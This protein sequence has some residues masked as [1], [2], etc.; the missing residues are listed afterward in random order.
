MK[1]KVEK[2]TIK[3]VK[4]LVFIF[5]VLF[6]GAVWGQVTINSVIAQSPVHFAENSDFSVG[7]LTISFN[8]PTGKTSGELQVNLAS[9]IEYM[10]GTVTA[11]G[12]TVSLKTGSTDAN[13]PVF[14]LTG[15]SGSVTVKLKRKATKAVLT[16]PALAS[17][18]QDEAVLTVQGLAPSPA[19]K[20]TAPY[21][22][23]RPTL[24]VQLPTIQT[25]VLGTRTE[26]FDIRNT[27]NGIVKD[28]YFSIAYDHRDVVGLSVSHNGTPL[29]QVGTVPTGLPNAGKPIYKIANANLANNGVVT[30]TEKYTVNKCTT[31]RQ[32]IY[33]AYWGSAIANNE[34]IFETNSNTRNISVSTGTP[35]IK[36]NGSNAF[37]YFE[38]KNGFCGNILGTYYVR[39]DNVTADAKGTAYNLEI[40]L[41]DA[42]E[43][44]KFS[45]F[46]PV[47]IRLIAKNGT[48]IPLA[49][50]LDTG[51]TRRISLSNLPALSDTSLGATDFGLTDAD[52]DGFR[53]DLKKGDYFQIAFDL[54]K[55]EGITCLQPR[56]GVRNFL[57]IQP[58]SQVLSSNV[59]GDLIPSEQHIL[60]NSTLRVYFNGVNDAS[61]LPAQ[62]VQNVPS[63]AYIA[64]GMNWPSLGAGQR[65]KNG[66]AVNVERQFKYV[67]T[68]PAGMKLQN[69]KLYRKANVFGVSTEA[70]VN[71]PDIE[72]NSTRTIITN[73]QPSDSPFGTPGYLTFDVLLQNCNGGTAPI[74]YS[75]YMMLKNGDGTY[76]DIPLVCNQVTNVPAICSTPCAIQGPRMLSTKVERADNSYGWKDHT[77]AIRQT[78]A[79]V[80][81]IERMRAL[82]LDDIEFISEGQQHVSKTDT[83]LFYYVKVEKTAELE[84]KKITLKVNG[85]SEQ[86]LIATANNPMRGTDAAGKKYFRWNLTSLLP[87]GTLVAGATF[88]TVATYQVKN[89]NNSNSNDRALDVQSGTES[90]FYTLD[91]PTTDTN[92]SAEGYHTAQKHCGANLTP[93]FY[94]AET[95]H[96]LA[97]N[98]YTELSG[99]DAA[100]L[101]SNLIYAARR[102]KPGGTYF[103]QEFRPAR[104]IKKIT[105]KMPSA[106]QIKNMQFTYTYKMGAATAATVDMSKLIMTDDGTWKTYTYENPPKGTL[107]YLPPGMITVENEYN[108]YIKA[109]IQPSCKAKTVDVNKKIEQQEA[110]AL[111]NQEKIDS[112]IEY[113]DFY[114][115]YADTGDSSVAV[116]LQNNR[117]ILFAESKKPEITIEAISQLTVKANKR[118]ME[119]TFKLKNAKSYDAPFGWIS[120]PDVTGIEVLSLEEGGHTYTAQNSISGEKM[121]FLSDK[122][123]DGK[124]LKN[125][126]RQF[127]LKYKITNCAAALQLKVYAGWNCN[128]DPTTGYRNTCSDKFITYNI[129]VAQSK[130]EIRADPTNPGENKPNKKGEIPM[131]APTTYKYEIN[132]AEEGDI[133]NAKLV[134]TQGNGITISN[135]KVEYPLGGTVYTVG[136]GAG[137]ILHTQS[138]NR[139]TYDISNILPEGSLPG[140][141][142]EPN[143]ANKRKFKLTFDV[144]P[145][146][147][148]SAGSSFDIDVEGTNLCDSP[149]EG[150]KT[151]AIIAGITGANVPD[152]GVQI[153]MDKDLVGNL[154]SCGNS[155]V[156]EITAAITHPTPLYQ[157]NSTE[158][159]VHVRIPK[160][161]ELKSLEFT[162]PPVLL[163]PPPFHYPGPTERKED[164]E[165]V[166]GDEQELVF[167]IPKYA[168]P[169]YTVGWILELQQ[170]D[171]AKVP[172]DPSKIKAFASDRVTGIT[173]NGQACPTLPR[174]ITSTTVEKNLIN[175]RPALSFTDLNI[176]SAAKSGKEELTIKYKLSNAVTTTN[177]AADLPATQQVKIDLYKDINN[178]GRFDAA[179]TKLSTTPYTFQEAV[180]EGASSSEKTITALVDQGDVCRLLLVINNDTNKCLCKDVYTQ[181][182][183]PATLT[184]LVPNLTVCEGETK[185]VAY[186]AA[187]YEVYTWSGKTIDDN[188]TYLSA[189]NVKEP[190]F[191]YTGTKLTATKSFTYILKV[192]RTNGCEAT[193]E[194]TVTVTP[195]TAAP[196]NKEV[197]FCQGDN[198]KVSTLKTKLLALYPGTTI[199]IYDPSDA[200]TVLT[201]NNDVAANANYLFTI[202]RTG[203]C[204][205]RQATVYVKGITLPMVAQANQTFCGSATVAALQPHGANYV[206]YAAATGGA[207]LT[208]STALTN[209]TYYVAKKNGTCESERVAVAVQL[210]TPIA[211]G[212]S[213]IFCQGATVY[214]LKK[215]LDATRPESVRIY[216]NNILLDRDNERLA[217]T[218]TFK[219]S[220]ATAACETAKVDVG[221]T[222]TSLAVTKLSATPAFLPAQGGSVTF[223]IEGTPGAKVSYSVGGNT[224]EVTLNTSGSATTTPV[225]APNGATIT[226]TKIEKGDC[227]QSLNQ[228]LTV[229]KACE[230][231]PTPQFAT[232]RNS[233]A[234]MNGVVVHR[235]VSGLVRPHFTN[236]ITAS[237]A[238]NAPY[239][240]GYVHMH[241]TRSTKVVYTFEKPINSVDVFLM[242]MGEQFYVDYKDR[243]RFEVNCGTTTLNIVNECKAGNAS[244]SG[245]VL[246]GSRL[247]DVV[248]RVSSDKPF[249]QLIVRQNNDLITDGYAM[250][251]CPSS[252]KEADL[253]Q[254]ITQPQPTT[255][256]EGSVAR[257]TSKATLPQGFTGDIGYQWQVSPNGTSSWS[258]VGTTRYVNSGQEVEFLLTNATPSQHD[259]RYYRVR[260]TY[261]NTALICDTK[262]TDYSQAAK[263]T[264]N[265]KAELTKLTATPGSI[266]QGVS[267]SVTFA[268]KGTP[269]AT[270]VYT[271]AGGAPSEVTLDTNGDATKILPLSQA[272]TLAVVQVKTASCTYPSSQKVQVTA[273]CGANKPEPLFA[274][275][276]EAE[277]T[278]G[279]VKVTRKLTGTPTFSGV[280]N[281][282]AFCHGNFQAGYV[283]MG[284][285]LPLVD[286]TQKVE[287]E[288]DTPVTNAEIWLMGMGISGVTN[289]NFKETA[290]ISVDCGHIQLSKV[291][292]CKNAA[293]INGQEVEGKRLTDVVVR[294]TSDNPFTKITIEDINSDRIAAG[295]YVALCPSSIQ[296]AEVLTVVEDPQT[297][298]LCEGKN[299]TFTAKV[300]RETGYNEAIA[301][302]WEQST[303]NGNTWTAVSGQSGTT[304]GDAQSLNLT[305]ITRAM[306]E[307]WY[308]VKYTYTEATP[309]RLCNGVTIT[310][311]TQKAQLKVTGLDK[312]TLTQVSA[313]DCTN[314]R[315]M[316]LGNVETD[317]GVTY[318]FVNT[319]T[320][321][322]VNAA[323][324]R[325]DGTI[326]GLPA[327]T[328]KVTATKNGCSSEAS[329]VFT[330]DA[331][332]APA[333]PTVQEKTFA[334]CSDASVV[335]I[336]N[337]VAGNYTFTK[338][339]GTA[340]TET[341]TVDSADGTITGLAVGKYKVKVEKDGCT[342]A[343]SAVFEIKDK[344]QPAKPRIQTVANNCQDPTAVTLTNY[345]AGATYSFVKAAD[346]SAVAE[347]INI[348]N[349][350]AV[351]GLVAGTYKVKV[352]VNDCVSDLSD[353]FEVKA[354]KAGTAI[355]TQPQGHNYAKNAT[356]DEIT[357]GATGEGNLRYK[358]FMNT[359]NS[360]TGADVREIT[361]ATTARYTPA[362]RTV[363]SLFYWVEV[364]GDCD[365]KESDIVEIKVTET[366]AAI[367]ANN[368]TA[369]VRRGQSVAVLPNDYVGGNPATLTNVTIAIDSNDG[370]TGATIDPQGRIKVPTN[371]TPGTYNVV[372]KICLV[373]DPNTCDNATAT[374]TVTNDPAYT[375]EANDDPLTRVAKGGTV[376]VLS[377]DQVNGNP[378]TPT[379]MDMTIEDNGGLSN[380]EVNTATGKLKVPADATPGTYE[381]TYR[382]C[383]KGETSPCD[384]AKVKIEVTSDAAPTKTI[385]ANDDPN[386]SVAKGGSVEVLSN[387]RLNGEP[388]TKDKVTITIDNDAGLTGVEID[389]ATGKI[390]VP[391]TAT[392]D[393]YEVTYKICDKQN[394]ALCDNANVKITVTSDVIHTIDANDDPAV[395][396][397]KGGTVTVLDNDQVDG[398]TATKDTVDISIVNHGNLTG[399]TVD[400]ATGKLKV[401][402]HAA[403]GSYEVTYRICLKGASAPCD[404][405][406]VKITVTNDTGTTITANNDPLTQVTKGGTADVLSNDRL[407]GDPATKDKVT[408]TI[409]KN[410]GLTGVMIDDATGK[411]KIP[412]NATPGEYEVTYKIC[413]KVNNSPC[414][415]AK[416]KLKV[417][418]DPAAT[419]TIQANDDPDTRVRPGDKVE[420][421]S[422][423]RLNGDPATKDKVMISIH[424]D[425][426]LTGVSV[427]AQTGKIQIPTDAP[428]RTYEVT[429]KICERQNGN[430]CATAKVKVSVDNDT[431]RTIEAN[432][433]PLTRVAKGGTV[434]ILSNDKVDGR[435]ADKDKVNFSIENSG[436]LVGVTIEPTTGKIKVPANATPGTYEVTYKIC[437]K[438]QA[439]LCDTATVTI[440]V[441]DAPAGTPTITAND[442]P[443]TRVP[444]GG[445]VDVL[446]NDYVNGDPATKDNVVP[447]IDNDGGLPGVTIDSNTGK[448]QIPTDAT[449]GTYPVTY[450][451][452]ERQNGNNCATAKVKI[453]VTGD[454]ASTPTITA[455]N[456]PEYT[457]PAGGMVDI[458]S[459]D[460]VNGDPV[461]P[462]QL[463]I[464][465][466]NKGGLPDLII[467]PA[468][469]KLKVPDTASAGGPYT[470]T[471]QICLSP[472]G[473]PCDEAKAIIKVSG[474]PRRI[475]A[476]DDDLGSIPNAVNYTSTHTVFSKGVDTLE[477]G[478]GV[479]KPGEDVILHPGTAPHADISMDPDTGK[480]TIKAGTP[481]GQY[482]YQYTICEKNNPDN[483]SNTATVRF[484]VK[485]S[486]IT[487]NDDKVWKVGTKGGLTP[488]ILNNDILNGKTGLS[489]SDVE[490]GVP[491]GETNDVVHFKMNEDGRIKVEEGL[492]PGTYTYHYVIKD[493]AN[494]NV[495]D[496]AKV[497]IEI[498]SFAAADDE[499]TEINNQDQPKTIEESVLKNDELD[500]RTPLTTADVDITPGV[501]KDNNNNPVDYFTFD[502]T[503]GKITIKPH[504]PNGTYSF[505]YYI[506]KKGTSECAGPAQ[507]TIKLEAVEAVDDDYS[508][509]PVNTVG[510]TKIIGNVLDND[511]YRGEPA[512]NHKDKIVVSRH[513]GDDRIEIK[514]TGEVIVPQ[515]MP[516]DT[517]ELTYQLCL[518]ESS[519]TCDTAKITVVVFEDKPLVIHNGI[520]ADGD[521]HNDSF[522]IEGIELYPDNNLKI[523]N[524]WGVLV[525]EKDGYRND[526]E[527]F[528]G[529]SNGRATIN[530]SSKLPQGTYYYI[531]DYKDTTGKLQQEKGWLYLKY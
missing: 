367:E 515:G 494:E 379:A 409:D 63:A 13:K 381:V 250:E 57:S 353:E 149:A 337:Y 410:G 491:Q 9:G 490:I 221:V 206:W 406:K 161:Y 387:D 427:D 299:A 129:T 209:D 22:L 522:I 477:G 236:A 374:I 480:I 173:C 290:K 271:V 8:M 460:R 36:Y 178:N 385:N 468:S 1:K 303:D 78:R 165:K 291:S 95:R 142:N 166:I 172:C 295:Y 276:N 296:K 189:A 187:S 20:N 204:A 405:A 286:L 418:D 398:A 311:Y 434:D 111:T 524:R 375:I 58:R 436:R 444:K 293:T 205:S 30:I 77:M 319:T 350:G 503:T 323:V 225:L 394:G 356:A 343:E 345:I 404:T 260:Y 304:T 18:L 217:Q 442:D 349:D 347:T 34:D 413:E 256:C 207:A 415:T 65:L 294:V 79:N 475:E 382:I 239:D 49:A 495:Y 185:Q 471:Y 203:E 7:E 325:T 37:T 499:F 473:T 384:T 527:P 134:V 244:I 41:F 163:L 331:A 297:V 158:A 338:E 261:E 54:K 71:Q 211:S 5:L 247:N 342:S 146:C 397:A 481:A 447:S 330:I 132:S 194:V 154:S 59:C 371:A 440:E 175:Q 176:T 262:V 28:V 141:L 105:I 101:G 272:T 386:T 3:N 478:S 199:A 118:T 40:R 263:L 200:N 373:S 423:D 285:R 249:T 449:P 115:H 362:T 32:N 143:N 253:L 183:P 67:I 51:D 75:V 265:G 441:V 267:T 109:F 526:T 332:K 169:G 289:R 462:S 396:V 492:N 45:R 231:K 212:Q 157:L 365:T 402:A 486:A 83:N 482:E 240:A 92:I 138:G 516:A 220:R 383:I 222:F 237:R 125:S 10:S 46:E 366:I 448:I 210:L 416:I 55:K 388:V 497:T 31:G 86:I 470:V 308:R 408:V 435:P 372:Y 144:T 510:G 421:L 93:V 133:Y 229:G 446:S 218:G 126:E 273:G 84:P 489:Q 528:D 392:E 160:G 401:P 358:W 465:I 201:D 266:A 432:N 27:G 72:P 378:A 162:E 287:Y 479:L 277:A 202:T 11:T 467:D 278:V 521:G 301:Y 360:R 457:V 216:H 255:V 458:L 414:A 214:D 452:C 159:R 68:T 150:D 4:W 454:S 407:G 300:E 333:Q 39:Y 52:N 314:D 393:T 437:H 223:T 317:L 411:I 107:G 504:T 506:C 282:P 87:A 450:K 305:A 197:L 47:D 341:I 453:E 233:D 241:S 116:D 329:D 523:F 403:A 443:L 469:G 445:T 180:V 226:L 502:T 155:Q 306:N 316:K 24:A 190:N 156:I 248:V 177:H 245:N 191:H 346:N 292:D 274:T 451:I 298:T 459:N 483:C 488:S 431:I 258:D 307:T 128:G 251:L 50:T 327:G 33:Y 69:V 456:D 500:G 355:T 288:F 376:N 283:Y 513:S 152:Y 182:A 485:A 48:T 99:C 280:D 257:F 531:L 268:F 487:A 474:A 425:G 389:P 123:N 455:N 136:T 422:N 243:A 208:D 519:N 140:S 340:V 518:K 227:E 184:N 377:N 417:T 238:C 108:E 429:Y 29:T 461:S 322:S 395:T 17:G 391:V 426:G 254:V 269:G 507:V 320:N 512:I 508:A 336:T 361:T 14:T 60:D 168:I 124:I 438:Q 472:A 2:L 110:E 359:T 352:K 100:T 6:T 517:Y 370:L 525:Y 139:H 310:R 66:N 112:K 73:N 309:T 234:T 321:Q 127:K 147:D 369:T 328:Y 213:F 131:C 15:A 26:T 344:L 174:L 170:K 511:R 153:T 35:I 228:S 315:K 420:V 70:A 121:F 80:S 88:S 195:Q 279:E 312:P 113:E 122:G 151:R 284:R 82:Y 119:A 21:V 90:F 439:G 364:T 348:A 198:Y 357:V 106:Y 242:M 224:G 275:N 94:I 103:S 196:D 302:T 23:P 520:S 252:V 171:D 61:K 264:V 98:R 74:T 97:T 12:A 400:S 192:K 76:C 102:F 96:L 466:L 530:A 120:V 62:L 514:S 44:Q 219:A 430:P 38:W 529:H 148:F 505:S 19:T 399:L 259:G 167:T 25:D 270:V 91:N 104:L 339:D 433:D 354:R 230:G 463:T 351:T 334:S 43:S 498:V 419:P 135:V 464:T 368:D 390:K 281:D 501:F 232:Q 324:D 64:P 42:D 235:E 493:K 424:N 56:I 89:A 380:L 179:D 246:T 117:P 412:D 145:D 114:Y 186:G 16:N 313:A 81:P 326:T 335:K 193:Q 53:D 215:K 484:E 188:I 137:K 363:G 496:T 164:E 181:L 318:S 476:K 85:G 130:K 428:A 509:T